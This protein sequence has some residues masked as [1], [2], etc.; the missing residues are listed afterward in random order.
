LW[1]RRKELNQTEEAQI[2]DQMS[3]CA[4]DV[5]QQRIRTDNMGDMGKITSEG[6]GW[7][8]LSILDGA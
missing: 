5:R 1:P 8:F 6:N 7:T 4:L 2:G 3:Y